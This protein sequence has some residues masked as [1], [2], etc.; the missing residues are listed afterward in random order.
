MDRMDT[1]DI[2]ESSLKRY[3]RHCERSEA[4]YISLSNRLLRRASSQ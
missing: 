4:I 2:N 1:E 3:S